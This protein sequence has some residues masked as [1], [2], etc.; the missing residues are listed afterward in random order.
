[1][2][3]RE[4][5]AAAISRALS[6]S[7]ELSANFAARAA[8]KKFAR[9][10]IFSCVGG[11]CASYDPSP[12]VHLPLRSRFSRNPK[13]KERTGHLYLLVGEGHMAFNDTLFQLG[14]DLTRSSTA[15]EEDHRRVAAH[16]VH[17]DCA[18]VG[19]EDRKDFFIE[20]D[21]KRFAG[22]HL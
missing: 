17:E 13:G 21:G 20:R 14:M 3:A 8:G 18:H 15:Q 19:H 9:G 6:L 5:P 2:A 7:Q 16:V 4:V 12:F 1:G 10:Q 11:V 22:T